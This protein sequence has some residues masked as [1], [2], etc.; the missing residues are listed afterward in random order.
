MGKILAKIISIFFHPLLMP[1]YLLISLMWYAPSL[2]I[3]IDQQAF[4]YLLLVVAL[5]S[6]VIPLILLTSLKFS[7]LIPDFYL[8]NK[9]HRIIPFVFVA[10]IYGVSF[11]MFYTQFDF[12][13]IVHLTYFS[14]T[15]LLLELAL[16]TIYWKI[17][18][19][20]ASMA[21][22]FGIIYALQLQNPD[23]DLLY[24]LIA[25][26]LI[27]GIVGTSRLKLNSHTL[28]QIMVGM[29]LGFVSCFIT[30]WMWGVLK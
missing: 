28:S 21:G 17:S 25:V 8:E 27:S 15:L 30:V 29:L 1:S 19:H 26:I 14:I 7:D 22:T 5:T 9:N 24:L 23:I 2:L 20:S 3:P 11:Y 10:I 6:L 18:V 16:V 4:P 13:R 12:A